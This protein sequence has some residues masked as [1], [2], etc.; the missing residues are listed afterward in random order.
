MFGVFENDKPASSVGFPYLKGK[1][2]N[3]HLFKTLK[4]ANEYCLEWLGSYASCVPNVLEIN[5]EY[6]YAGSEDFIIIKE[7]MGEQ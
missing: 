2:W 6:H 7:V 1:G 5:T 4:E 3:N